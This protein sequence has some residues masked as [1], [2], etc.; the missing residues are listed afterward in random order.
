VADKSAH[1]LAIEGL[2]A[3]FTVGKLQAG[4]T[5]YLPAWHSLKPGFGVTASV[6]LVPNALEPAYGNRAS[7]GV[8]VFVTLRPAAMMMGSMP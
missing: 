7:F 3:I 1:D 6:S 4:Y 8:G 2:D 5:R